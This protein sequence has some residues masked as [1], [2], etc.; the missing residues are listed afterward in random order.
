MAKSVETLHRIEE[1]GDYLKNQSQRSNVIIDGVPE[2]K[3]EIGMSHVKVHEIIR[4]KLGLARKI[5]EALMK[6]VSD[7]LVIKLLCNTDDKKQR[8]KILKGKC[9][10]INTE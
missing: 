8:Q 4:N 3:V 9:R 7:R 10:H 1:K 2:E 5:K 6:A